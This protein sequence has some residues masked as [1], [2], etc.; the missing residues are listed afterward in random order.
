[1][2][3]SRV[4]PPSD[5]KYGVFG[6]QGGTPPLLS[7]KGYGITLDFGEKW[8]KKGVKIFFLPYCRVRD[9]SRFL[10]KKDQK[11]AILTTKNPIFSIQNRDFIGGFSAKNTL[12]LHNSVLETEILVYV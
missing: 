2:G 10:A 12:F 4:W 6:P 9:Y 3:K 7:Q 11:K 5:R 1:M 8:Q